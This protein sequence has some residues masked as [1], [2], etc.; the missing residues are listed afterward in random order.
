M[1]K[2]RLITF[3]IR[4]S[5]GHKFLGEWRTRKSFQG[6]PSYGKPT[7]ENL[8]KWRDGMNESLLPGGTNSHIGING[9]IQQQ[10]EIY[11]QKTGQIVCTYQP[12]MFEIIPNT[13]HPNS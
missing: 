1:S 7:S 10:I 11:N 3:I 5:R 8:S 4:T 9:W 12:P 13:L 2:D 6:I